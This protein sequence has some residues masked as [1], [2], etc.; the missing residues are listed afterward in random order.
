MSRIFLEN[1][2]DYIG[3]FIFREILR[4]LVGGGSRLP[5]D[6]IAG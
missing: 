5:E 6:P 3:E 1:G 2:T 4:G